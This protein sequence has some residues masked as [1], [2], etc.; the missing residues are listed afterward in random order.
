MTKFLATV[1]AM[2]LISANVLA[3]DE[4]PDALVK[5]VSEDVLNT[6]NTD[7]EI[8]SGSTKKVFELVENKIFPYVDFQRTTSMTAGRYWHQATPEQQKKLSNEFR[9]LLIN[10]YAG[11]ISKAKN[12][13]INFKPFRGSPTDTEVEVRSQVIQPG[14]EPIELD[15]RLEKTAAGWKIYDLNILGAWLVET[16]KQTF[17]SEISKSGIDGLIK[18]L[19]EKNNKLAR[20]STASKE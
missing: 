16:Y 9:R 19:E 3:A 1:L 14:G 8:Q 10:T 18:T 11:A 13:K 17:S 5:R 7:K 2:C 6:V 15:Y 12:H 20:S 4:A